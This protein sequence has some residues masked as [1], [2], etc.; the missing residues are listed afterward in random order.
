VWFEK[1]LT[2]RASPQDKQPNCQP[3]LAATEEPLKQQCWNL[4]TSPAFVVSRSTEIDAVAQ[5][6]HL[7]KQA[8]AQGDVDAQN[9]LARLLKKD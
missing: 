8:A 5:A 1:V 9:N 3:L 6:I 4:Q 2:A 7:Y